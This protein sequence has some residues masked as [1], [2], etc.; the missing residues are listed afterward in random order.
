MGF[1]DNTIKCPEMLSC[2][3]SHESTRD[4]E[5]L[6]FTLHFF[7]NEIQFGCKYLT[8]QISQNS[9]LNW[10]HWK[11]HNVDCVKVLTK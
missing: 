3:V 8:N 9:R 7:S 4:K 10:I 6:H 5:T 1:T 2:P 11:M